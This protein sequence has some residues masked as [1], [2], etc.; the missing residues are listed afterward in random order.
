M[1][2]CVL[3]YVKPELVRSVL[4]N[5][6]SFTGIIKAFPVYG[7][8]DIAVFI[9]M[10]EYPLIIL[11]SKKISLLQGITKAETYLDADVVNSMT[12]T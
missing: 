8:Y 2:A 7:R 9:E 11:L 3:I 6:R 4:Q 1:Y 12:R 5:L 10:E